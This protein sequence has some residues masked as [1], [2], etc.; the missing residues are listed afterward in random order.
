M[1]LCKEG[2]YIVPCIGADGC[3]SEECGA[4]QD[5]CEELFHRKKGFDDFDTK[6]KFF[7]NTT[8]NT[9]LQFSNNRENM[10]GGV[11]CRVLREE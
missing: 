3:T 10:V 8:K 1:A 4:E 6:K 2:I 9:D 7:T 5:E 11:G